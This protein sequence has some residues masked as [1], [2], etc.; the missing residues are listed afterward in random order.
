MVVKC[1]NVLLKIVLVGV[2]YMIVGCV[3]CVGGIW[4]VYSWLDVCDDL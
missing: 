3:G 1:F 2:V 4:V